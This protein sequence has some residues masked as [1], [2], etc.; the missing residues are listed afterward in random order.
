MFGHVYVA[1]SVCAIGRET[2]HARQVW[3][4]SHADDVGRGVGNA[5]GD[6]IPLDGSLRNTT[7]VFA[8]CTFNILRCRACNATNTSLASL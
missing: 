7:F 6:A 3:T 2:E 4:K 5:Y 8:I 1:T